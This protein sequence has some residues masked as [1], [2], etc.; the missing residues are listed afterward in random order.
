MAEASLGEEKLLLA[1]FGPFLG[2]EDDGTGK[3]VV[4]VHV[5]G[6]DL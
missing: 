1:V 3:S 5:M 4:A 2:V 6:F